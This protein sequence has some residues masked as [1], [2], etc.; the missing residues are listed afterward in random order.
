MSLE[1]LDGESVYRN[2]Q[3]IHA[4]H[5]N[6]MCQQNADFVLNIAL[7]VINGR[8]QNIKF[9]ALAALLFIVQLLFY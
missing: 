1:I 5:N 3:R 4:E 6:K 2:C 8:L 7:I 9:R